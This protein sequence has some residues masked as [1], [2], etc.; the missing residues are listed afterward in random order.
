MYFI[1]PTSGEI[2]YLCLLLTV[3]KG[4]TSFDDLRRVPGYQNLFP[5]FHAACLAQGLLQDDGEW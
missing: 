5:T 2:Y 3:V 4:A 1:K